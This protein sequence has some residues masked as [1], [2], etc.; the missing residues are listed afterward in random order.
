MTIVDV[1]GES[2]RYFSSSS[3]MMTPVTPETRP[4]TTAVS[5]ERHRREM[6]SSARIARG[7]KN[8][9]TPSTMLI[10]MNRIVRTKSLETVRTSCVTA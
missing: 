5:A 8:V 9:K 1:M 7:P 10:G 3:T 4:A 2:G 6:I